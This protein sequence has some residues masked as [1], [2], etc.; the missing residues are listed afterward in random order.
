MITL[1][2]C[3]AEKLDL[4]R[5]DLRAVRLRLLEC[6][7]ALALR[8]RLAGLKMFGNAGCKWAV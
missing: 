1:K 6:S 2:T 3:A 5:Y 7:K 4:F 8:G